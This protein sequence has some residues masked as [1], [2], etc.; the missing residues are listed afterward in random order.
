MAAADAGAT[1]AIQALSVAFVRVYNA[2]DLDS[3]VETFYTED[4][5]LP[6]A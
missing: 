5:H 4:A 1:C 2:G 3:L 6:A